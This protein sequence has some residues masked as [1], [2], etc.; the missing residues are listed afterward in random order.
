MPQPT[1]TYAGLRALATFGGVELPN[2]QGVMP[3][4]NLNDG[5]NTRLKDFGTDDGNKQISLAQ[6]LYMARGVTLARDFGPRGIAL[7][8]AYNEDSTHSIG[9][10]LASLAMAGEQ[11]L[12]FDGGLTYILAEYSGISGRTRVRRGIPL[13]WEFALELIARNPWF[14]DAA[15]TTMA[16]L[17]LTV[18]AGQAFSITYA[19]SVW[20]EPV[21][22]LHVPV[23]NAVAINS[24]QLKN[25]MSGEYLTVNFQSATAIPAATV[26]DVVIDCAAMTAI[27]TQTSESYDI[28]GSFPMLY[29]PA[30]TVNPFTVII[31]PATGASSGLTLAASHNPRWQI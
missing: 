3:L 6:L 14:Q 30:G 8:M 10:W 7:P 17:A 2:G 25:T 18:D 5:I 1:F 15:A 31:T 16:P 23:G 28:S 20:A 13:A 24:I 11:Q 12:S 27:C 19:G 26:R 4:V 9:A 29:Q 22:T 21:W